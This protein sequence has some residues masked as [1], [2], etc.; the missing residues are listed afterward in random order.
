MYL[1]KTTINSL[2]TETNNLTAEKIEELVN[3]YYSDDITWNISQ[4]FNKLNGKKEIINKFWL[5][6]LNAIPDLK[7]ETYVLLEGEEPI[8]KERKWVLSSGNF[9][10]NFKNN[11][12]GI[13]ATGGCIWMRYMEYNRLE[14]GKIVE[15]YILID[16]M[17]LMRQAG[18]NILDSLGNDINVPGPATY[19]GINLKEK[20]PTLTQKS[21]DTIF[22]LSWKSLDTFVDTGLG[23]MGIDQYFD[24][25]FMWYGPTGIGSIRSIKGFEEFH[26]NPFLKALPDRRYPTVDRE[27]IFFADNNYCTYIWWDHFKATHTGDDWLGLKATNNPLN[28][29]C[30]DIY[31]IEGNMIKENWVMLDMI[32][33]L[34]QLGVDAFKKMEELKVRKAA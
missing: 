5:P 28:M 10:G 25:D 23:K 19:D 15:S 30:S 2:N 3:K 14:S 21:Y 24:K 8:K 18:F 27:G 13:P 33:I 16:I 32:D 34:D 31:R 4:P 1:N 29:R 11:W 20:N 12:L 17:D 6:L 26:Q 9:I 7:K 22:D